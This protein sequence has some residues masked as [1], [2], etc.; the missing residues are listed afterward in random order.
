MSNRLRRDG[1]TLVELLVVIGIIALLISILLPSLNKAREAASRAACLSN[2]H[3]IHAGLVM[4][5]HENKDFLPLGAYQWCDRANFI[6]WWWD[7]YFAM[8]VTHSKQLKDGRI[9]YCPSES[10]PAFQYNTEP[11]SWKVGQ[12]GAANNNT[13]HP[14][15]AAGG[16]VAL[17]YGVRVCGPPASMPYA[18]FPEGRQMYWV[19][20]YGPPWTEPPTVRVHDFWSWE[21][22]SEWSP[23]QVK[24]KNMAIVADLFNDPDF[25]NARHRTGINVL[26]SN[27]SARWVQRAAF[28]EDLRNLPTIGTVGE[29][30]WW[31][32][33]HAARFNNIWRTLDRE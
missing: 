29:G 16:L 26:Y 6:A 31:S 1:F 12:V 11:N 18:S 3:Q 4:Y 30:G 32:Y 24:F 7:A 33:S 14:Y 28:N 15:Y 9:F 21:P 27:G 2:L 13:T 5:G 10:R 8:G 19:P 25:L 23:K 20:T 17:G 22:A